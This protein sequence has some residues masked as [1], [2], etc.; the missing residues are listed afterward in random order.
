MRKLS[1]AIALLLGV[2]LAE[3]YVDHG[4]RVKSKV[5]IKTVEKKRLQSVNVPDQWLWNNVNNTNFLTN[6]KN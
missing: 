5:P 1:L 4:C 3:D 6:M 2:V